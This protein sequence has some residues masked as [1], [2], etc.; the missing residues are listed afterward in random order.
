MLVELVHVRVDVLSLADEEVGDRVVELR[1]GEPM[2]RP[3]RMRSETAADLV[4]ALRARLELC[5]TLADAEID[6]LVIAGLE[7]QAVKISRAA[8]VATVESVAAAE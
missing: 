3:R 5:E 6:A 7:M 4:L 2:T 8:L 1:V